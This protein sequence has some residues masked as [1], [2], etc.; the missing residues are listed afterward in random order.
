MALLAGLMVYLS[1]SRLLP[2]VRE[3]SYPQSHMILQLA[4]QCLITEDKGS[5]DSVDTLLLSSHLH[6]THLLFFN[7]ATTI[8]VTLIW[9]VLINT[10]VHLPN[11]YL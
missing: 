8:L 11:Q 4:A 2:S 1:D 6:Q 3:T 9:S 10:Q 7:E 5:L